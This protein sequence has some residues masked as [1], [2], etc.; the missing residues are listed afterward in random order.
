MYAAMAIS[1]LS[2]PLLIHNWIAGVLAIPAFA[3]LCVVR[4]PLEEVMLRE[5]FGAA[6]DAY[7]ARTRRIIP[8][9]AITMGS[10]RNGGS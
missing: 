3:A 4:I 10:A 2:Q 8:G 5:R 9:A 7:A 6:Y 1:A